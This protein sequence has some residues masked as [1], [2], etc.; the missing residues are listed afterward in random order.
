VYS[1]RHPVIAMSATAKVESDPAVNAVR[2]K[3]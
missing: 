3:V 2:R 1:M